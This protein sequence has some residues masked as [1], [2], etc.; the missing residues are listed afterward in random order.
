VR[1]VEFPILRTYQVSGGRQKAVES[2][3]GRVENNVK[4]VLVGICFLYDCIFDDWCSI[5]CDASKAGTSGEPAMD[6]HSGGHGR[7]HHA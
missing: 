2:D 7:R 4:V 1:P 3:D 6:N 5:A